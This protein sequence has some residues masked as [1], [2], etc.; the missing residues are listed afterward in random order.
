MLRRGP[1][2]VLAG[3][4]NSGKSSLFNALLGVERA[5]VTEV[6]GTTRDAIEAE[7]VLGGFPFR[8]VDT[9]GLRPTADRVEVRG[10]EVAQRYVAAADIILFCTESRSHLKPPEHEFLEEHAGTPILVVRTK[11]DR[12][13][14]AAHAEG[15]RAAISVSAVT[16]EGLAVL[17]EQLVGFAFG[18]IRAAVADQPIITRERHARALTTA[19]DELRAFLFALDSEVPLDV[20]TTHLSAAAAAIEEII[21]IVTLDNVL[22]ILFSQF[23]VGK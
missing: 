10:I 9:A 5:I 11:A 17:R 22:D 7:V 12:V 20:A 6:P 19:A 21:G 15:E 18:G 4:P 13:S 14:A 16:G 23:C 8:L 3:H 2:V 1:L